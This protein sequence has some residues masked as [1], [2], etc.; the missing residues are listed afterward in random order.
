MTKRT[1]DPEPALPHA[2]PPIAAPPRRGPQ[3][4]PKGEVEA[5]EAEQTRVMLTG[6][7]RTVLTERYIPT[8]EF[9][10]RIF[11][12]GQHF[13]QIGEVPDSGARVFAPTR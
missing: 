6:D 13:E 7:D 9:G 12:D 5:T 8:A 3:P 11:V 1:D 2:E 4:L 10:F